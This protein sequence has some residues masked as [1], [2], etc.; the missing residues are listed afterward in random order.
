M[1]FRET[2]ISG[3]LLVEL[4]PV[5]DHRGFFARAFC[6]REFREHGINVEIMQAN[7]S[8]NHKR[9]TLR[10]MHYQTAPHAGAKLVRCISGEIFDA[11]IDLREDSATRGRWLSFTLSAENGHMLYVPPG[12]AHGYLAMT[13]GATVFYLTSETYTPSH[14]RGIRWNDPLFG[15]NWPKVW[16]EFGP[17]ISDKDSRHGDFSF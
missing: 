3:L 13:D 2:G 11:V 8:L 17:V 15:I 10:G 5:H 7:I 1:L 4:E 12:F 9:G 16:P 14:E 6:G